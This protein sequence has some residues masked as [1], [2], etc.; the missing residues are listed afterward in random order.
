MKHGVIKLNI[1]AD[2]KSPEATTESPRTTR[3]P[4]TEPRPKYPDS[5]NLNTIGFG[6]KRRPDRGEE[7]DLAEL[8]NSELNGCAKNYFN[9]LFLLSSVSVVE[10]LF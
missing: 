1:S 10:L 5:G 3:P 7:E 4:R 6:S 9:F 8:K 2:K